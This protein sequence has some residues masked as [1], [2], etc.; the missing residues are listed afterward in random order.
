MSIEK[1]NEPG[2]IYCPSCGFYVG[3]YEICPHCQASLQKRISLKLVKNIAVIGSIVGLILLWFAAYKSQIPQVKISELGPS[4]NNATVKVEGL[5]T[6]IQLD[7]VKDNFKITIEDGTGRL[8]L[9]GYGKLRQFKRAYKDGKFLPGD[10]DK[11]DPKDDFFS[12]GDRISVKG[13]ISINEKFGATMFLSIP[14]RIKIISM[15]S[16]KGTSFI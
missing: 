3:A 8:Q 11:E 4:M 9:G 6:K 2:K 1:T 15:A 10:W 7:E 16:R 12:E 5:I 14:R 13:N